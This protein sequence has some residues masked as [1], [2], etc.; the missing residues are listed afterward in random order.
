[1]FSSKP[2][3]SWSCSIQPGIMLEMRGCPL[4]MIFLATEMLLF[5]RCCLTQMLR[6][7]YITHW[8]C[9]SAG[10]HASTFRVCP[11]AGSITTTPKPGGLVLQVAWAELH[12]VLLQS[13][14]RR[15]GAT[16]LSLQPFPTKLDTRTCNCVTTVR[17][18]QYCQCFGMHLACTRAGVLTCCTSRP[19]YERLQAAL[20]LLA[21]SIK[22]LHGF[23]HSTELDG[24]RTVQ[25]HLPA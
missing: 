1:M 12:L 6:F 7:L 16:L 21:A 4:S 20:M 10:C 18:G 8:N 2:D 9:C 25:Y 17:Q 5:A 13:P 24:G 23:G 22:L 19:D 3:S 11:L 15:F 14:F